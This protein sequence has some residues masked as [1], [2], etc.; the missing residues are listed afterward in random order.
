MK[1]LAI[2][3][4]I[5]VQLE[6]CVHRFV[7]WL[8]F[9]HHPMVHVI[10]GTA[11][12]PIS[13]TTVL[14]HWFAYYSC[15]PGNQP[16]RAICMWNWRHWYVY[17]HMHSDTKKE[18][19][20]VVSRSALHDCF[21]WNGSCIWEYLKK[22]SCKRKCQI[23]IC[24]FTYIH[25][26]KYLNMHLFRDIDLHIYVYTSC[27]EW[28]TPAWNLQDLSVCEQHYITISRAGKDL[29]IWFVTA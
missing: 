19:R 10:A 25:A 1:G 12:Q 3:S 7:V 24:I 8:G 28:V 21:L 27:H 18:N 17:F 23:Q 4:E 14:L 11:W 22:V 2:S 5:S 6:T 29:G 20:A 9:Y 13:W 15:R 26:Y 16:C